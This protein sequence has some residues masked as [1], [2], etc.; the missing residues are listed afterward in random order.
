MS[1]DATALDLP[2]PYIALQAVHAIQ[3][4]LAYPVL[5]LLLSWLYRVGAARLPKVRTWSGRQL[6]RFGRV[7]LLVVNL[8]IVLPL[9]LA[10]AGAA[11]SPALVQTTSALSE[12][13]SL[14]QW[15]GLA[16]LVYVVWL[17]LGPG[18]LLL[19]ALQRRRI[20]PIVL[21][22][23][24]YF[25]GALVDTAGRARANAE[26]LM[27]GESDTSMAVTFTLAAGVAPLPRADLLLVAIRNGHYFVVERQPNPP[28]L[29]PIAFAIPFRAVD[30]VHMERVNPAAPA[31]HG[32][33]VDFFGSTPVP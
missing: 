31:A 1:I 29:T 13:V 10:A 15:A 9:I 26:H 23:A 11:S 7:A 30:A 32:I 8:L 33:I 24:L 21:L 12:V 6:Q 4:L 28:S 20:L 25:C 5:L 19:A 17:S 16:L 14:M 18:T 27:T 3:S 2:P 22:S